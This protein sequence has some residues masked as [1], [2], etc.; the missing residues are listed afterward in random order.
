M[1]SIARPL[2][3]FRLI[4]G[5]ILLAS[6]SPAELAAAVTWD[7]GAVLDSDWSSNLNWAGVGGAAADDVLIFPVT[8]QRKS[9]VNDFGADTNFAQLNFF[10]SGYSITGARIFLASSGNASTIGIDSRVPSGGSFVFAPSI[11]LGKSLVFQ[12]TGAA[13]YTLNGVITLEGH[14]LS[15]TG[16]GDAILNGAISGAG[17]PLQKVGEGTA[18]LNGN[19]SG[20]AAFVVLGGT[21]RVGS[22]GTIGD[23]TLN[24]GTLSGGG[25]VGDLNAANTTTIAPGIGA[26][27]TAVL[28]AGNVG[29]A[30]GAILDIELGGLTPGTQHDKLSV[31]GTISLGG[32]TLKGTLING[33]IPASGNQFTIIQS[34]SL[35]SG[36]FAQGALITFS[37]VS[38]K[39]IYNANSVVLTQAPDL[40]LTKTHTGNFGQG[41]IGAT[42]TA[43]VANP[44]GDKLPGNLVSLVDTPPAGL[45]VTAMS[46]SGW[47]C[48]VLPTCT[49]SDLLAAGQLYPAI[50][51]TVTVAA[52]ATSPQVNSVAVTTAVTESNTAN[53]SASDSTV[54]VAGL[55]FADGFE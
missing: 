13:P 37:G 38:F 50:T 28:K 2:C 42:Y 31:T 46:G 6:F 29:L 54:I 40:T 34:T 33:F 30:P 44:G 10:G 32:A 51:I 21:L 53:N 55:I 20:L 1:R 41:Q 35:L 36:Q 47:T 14:S 43:T 9:N 49:R 24:G 45:T 48:T 17:G 5:L 22:S 15:L 27:T 23:V 25:T 11:R 4:G 52:D 12:S 39:I 18:T 8:A 3:V 26:G 16:D 19:S 7:G